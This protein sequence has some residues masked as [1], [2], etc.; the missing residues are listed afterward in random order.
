MQEKI[1]VD[2]NHPVWLSEPGY[3]NPKTLNGPYCAIA[4]D[5]IAVNNKKPYIT[6]PFNMYKW[7]EKAANIDESQVVAIYSCNDDYKIGIVNDD[8][9]TKP[10]NH[11]KAVRMV[12]EALATNPNVELKGTMIS[13][14]IKEKVNV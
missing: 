4:K 10:E 6:G 9:Q 12:L 8:P 14:V 3:G 5:Y 7:L 2:L 11:W 1:V 13:D